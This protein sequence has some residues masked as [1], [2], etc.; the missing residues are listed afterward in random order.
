MPEVIIGMQR[1]QR[2]IKFMKKDLRKSTRKAALEGAKVVR[3]RARELA[4]KK[5]G[6]LSRGIRARVVQSWPTMALSVVGF[7]RR[8]FYGRFLEL[9]T[10]KISAKP[11]LRPALDEMENVA[12]VTMGKVWRQT[13]DK[14]RRVR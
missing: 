14:A 9:G 10:S 8:V 3:D 5:T 4:P 6:R 12:V 11:F 13:L 2:K 1:L 7:D